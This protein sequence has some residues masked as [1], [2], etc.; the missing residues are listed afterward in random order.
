[1]IPSSL[2]GPS[3]TLHILCFRQT[4]QLLGPRYSVGFLGFLPCQANSVQFWMAHPRGYLP[5]EAPLHALP[6]FSLHIQNISFPAVGS[7]KTAFVHGTFM[8]PYFRWK[9]WQILF[10]GLQNHCSDCSRKIKRHLL[11]GRKAM[12]N[13]DS[14]LKIRDITL[15]TKVRIVKAMV[16]QSLC[17]DVRVVP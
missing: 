6:P 17:T 8:L 1:M 9:Q 15:P 13:L 12:I 14:I 4:R 16:F 11:F 7:Q 5:I 10:W 2:P 3:H